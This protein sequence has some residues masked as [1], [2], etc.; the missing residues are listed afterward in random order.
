[1]G[2][3]EEWLRTEVGLEMRPTCWLPT[4]RVSLWPLTSLPAHL[5]H[6]VVAEAPFGATQ[7]RPSIDVDGPPA[8]IGNE[9]ITIVL[10]FDDTYEEREEKGM[11][12]WRK[13][14]KEPKALIYPLCFLGKG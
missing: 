8:L 3:T 1:M 4:S 7:H 2:G 13:A 10:Q 9:E 5:H 6:G 14:R 12:G 11:M